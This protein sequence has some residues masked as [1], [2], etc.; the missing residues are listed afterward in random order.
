MRSDYWDLVKGLSII[1]VVVIHACGTTIGNPIDSFAYQFTLVLRCVVDFAVPMFLAVSGYFSVGKQSMRSI[2]LYEKRLTR[3]FIPYLFWTFVFLALAAVQGSLPSHSHV[4]IVLQ[5][6]FAGTGIGIGYFV[7]VLAQMILL[8][9][10]LSSIGSDRVHWAIIA[11]LTVLGLTATYVLRLGMPESVLARF[12]YNSIFFFVWYPF[13]HLG[14]MIR[15]SADV[16][17]WCVRHRVSLLVGCCL[18]LVVSIV[19]GEILSEFSPQI[20]APSQLRIS[21][22]AFSILLFLSFVGFEREGAF[23]RGRFLSWIGRNSYFIYLFHFPLLGFF[24]RP[25]ME[26]RFAIENPVILIGVVTVLTLLASVVAIWMSTKLLPTRL[27][28]ALLGMSNDPARG[29]AAQ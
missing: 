26:G 25:L 21:S 10:V 8:T 13:Y 20:F 18:A 16:R 9:P 6:V 19:E 12:P 11:S 2:D 15:R 7:I 17:A 3:I 27:S 28:F 14:M 29:R 4:R 23:D 1:A 5:A 22:F 24:S